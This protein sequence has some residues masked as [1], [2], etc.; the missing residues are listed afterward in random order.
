MTMNREIYSVP[1]ASTGNK[2]I[3]ELLSMDLDLA[4]MFIKVA[5]E[6]R[7]P[8]HGRLAYGKARRAYDTAVNCLDRAALN[9][10][11]LRDIRGRC[12]QLEVRLCEVKARLHLI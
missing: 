4:G 9:A 6:T 2:L 10:D 3:V 11:Q 7:S 1:G 5:E 12:C 8:A